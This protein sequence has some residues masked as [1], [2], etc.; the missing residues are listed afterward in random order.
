M[1]G[2]DDEEQDMGR[3]RR[4]RQQVY[5][6][7]SELNAVLREPFF[8]EPMTVSRVPYVFYRG[9]K[10]CIVLTVRFNLIPSFNR[11]FMERQ[12]LTLLDEHT[13][14]YPHRPVLASVRYDL[15]LRSSGADRAASYYIWRANTNQAD[16]DDDDELVFVPNYANVF[17]FCNNATHINMSDLNIYFV[18]SSVVID[19]CIAIVL[20]FVLSP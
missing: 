5:M 14:P 4:R 11:H 9:R 18:N 19:K 12:L 17:Q 2:N 3:R 8:S 16:F 7:L 1:V 6:S 15:V 13:Q 10:K 20:S